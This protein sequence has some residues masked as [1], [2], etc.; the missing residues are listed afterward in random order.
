MIP[1]VSSA[2][3]APLSAGIAV[4]HRDAAS[5]LAIVTGHEANRQES[6]MNWSALAGIDTRGLPHGRA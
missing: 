1:G 6:R 2:L 3:A 4:T 5:S